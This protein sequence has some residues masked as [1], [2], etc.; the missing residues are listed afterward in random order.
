M[1]S[2]TCGT[3]A[4]F[5]EFLPC[6]T[7]TTIIFNLFCNKSSM[8]RLTRRWGLFQCTLDPN[9]RIFFLEAQN[10]SGSRMEHFEDEDFEEEDFE[11]EDFEL[12][13][14]VVG[15]LWDNLE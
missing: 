3:V 5:V 6:P 8:E 2:C 14:C 4:I 7:E 13:R 10:Y 15:I 1:G 11:D 12:V 9:K